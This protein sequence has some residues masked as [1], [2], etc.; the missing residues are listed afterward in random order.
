MEKEE[1][2]NET[3]IGNIQAVSNETKIGIKSVNSPFAL[4]FTF[5]DYYDEKAV[6]RFIKSVEKLIRQSTEYKTYIE[7]LRTNIH[8]LNK[9]NIL[10]NITTGDVDLEF[11]HYPFSLYELIEIVMGNHI[12]NKETFTSFSLAKEIMELHYKH[13]IGLV[14][15]TRTT[16]ELAHSGKIFLSNKQIFGNYQEFIKIY[17]N[18]ISRELKNKIEN[19]NKYSELGVPSDFNEVL[20]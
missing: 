5:D 2:K 18:S 20:K 16:H 4:A 12:I 11:H 8:A 19:M 1:N 6:K 14:P 10:S 17:N 7:L 13:L 15:L 9:D 3:V